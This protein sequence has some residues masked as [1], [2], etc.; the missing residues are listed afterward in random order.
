MTDIHLELPCFE[1]LILI[2]MAHFLMLLS[3]AHRLISFYA[4]VMPSLYMQPPVLRPVFSIYTFEQ[5]EH[6][7]CTFLPSF[8][9]LRSRLFLAASGPDSVSNI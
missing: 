6:I 1:Q 2:R 3:N 8:A 5:F 4:S 9:T 7:Y